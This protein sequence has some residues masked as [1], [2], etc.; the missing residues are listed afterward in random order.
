MK[1]KILKIYLSIFLI[2]VFI[3]SAFP[4]YDLIAKLNLPSGIISAI[5]NYG[6]FIVHVA[7]FIA[8]F[9]FKDLIITTKNKG[10]QA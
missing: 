4:V 9:H 5:V 10:E 7:S 1:K 2:F 8:M 6:Y 3:A